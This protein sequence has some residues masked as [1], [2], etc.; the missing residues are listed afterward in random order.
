MPR[1]EGKLQDIA[2]ISW[3][4]RRWVVYMDPAYTGYLFFLSFYLVEYVGGSLKH[5]ILDST[6]GKRECEGVLST[7]M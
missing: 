7:Y 1:V 2:E 5:A 6:H 3:F 4:T